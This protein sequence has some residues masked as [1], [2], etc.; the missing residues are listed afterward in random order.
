M[1]WS[2][3]IERFRPPSLPP[4][5]CQMI[6]DELCVLA[7][8]EIVC[9]CSD[10]S[11][12]RVYGNVYLD[13]IADIYN[14]PMYQEMR[15]WQL[16]TKPDSWCPVNQSFC[17]G[18]VT[19]ATAR[20]GVGARV[21][22][23]LQLEPISFCN[24]KCPACPVTHFHTDALYRQD[25]ATILPLETMLSVVAQLPD[26]EK[27]LFYNFGEPFLHKDAIPFL[28]AVRQQRPDVFL[29]TSTNGLP[30]TPEKITALASEA[31]VDH[32]VFS[33][34]GAWEQSYRRYRVN[35]NLQRALR[36]MEALAQACRRAGTA[37]RVT[38]L[39]QYI[40]FEW[41]DSDEELAEARRLAAEMGVRLKWVFTHT[42]GASTRYPEGSEAA[43]RLYSGEAGRLYGAGDAYHGLTC[44][45]RLE[46]LW[47]HGGVAAGR[48]LARLTLDP[49]ELRGLAG[50]RL[51]CYLTV[52]N[53]SPSAWR[54]E[55]NHRYLIG[56]RWHSP[57]GRTLR[58]R[59]TIPVPPACAR[60][61]GKGRVLLD[62]VLP[63]TPGR[64]ELF[65][66]VV[67][68]GVCW[69]SDRSS[70]PLVCEVEVTAGPRQCWDYLPI[71]ER[72]YQVLLGRDP[73]AEGLAYWLRY[74]ED[75][76]S[77]QG[78]MAEVCRIEGLRPHRRLQKQNQQLSRA[79]LADIE[80]MRAV[81][82][83]PNKV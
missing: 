70:P 72:T 56:L 80:A 62:V 65:L 8:G 9:S 18:R 46:H 35:G 55:G 61:G 60:P 5:I 54:D 66:D 19:R 77:V 7:N 50:S 28:R 78:F 67:E 31:L 36:N 1:Q 53:L 22:R 74:L 21:V 33:I 75:G 57:I 52:E 4:M 16:T 73:D 81:G 10:P 68:N 47:R 29:A 23:M 82:T 41:N 25:R 45:L 34:D 26:L 83:T 44:D 59:L 17:P 37:N 3:L 24:L 13:R 51:A 20:H 27:I 2:A 38:I 71:V 14:G 6:F 79:L 15:R 76:G 42:E 32:I 58:E 63:E 39:W 48:Y 40:L 49:R 12:I 30:F 64:Y 69:F 11:G 43:A